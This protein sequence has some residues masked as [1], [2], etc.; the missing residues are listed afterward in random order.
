M[1]LPLLGMPPHVIKG[2]ID[3]VRN[4][5]LGRNVDFYRPIRSA[6]SLCA[7]SG[8]YNPN[9]DG[10][11]F[12]NC[13]VCSGTY[14]ISALEQNTIIA[15]VHWVNDEA[16]EVTPGGKFFTGEATATI[17]PAYLDL[18]ES[19]QNNEG[20]VV[21]DG[22]DMEIVRIIPMGAP[23]INRYRVVLRNMGDRPA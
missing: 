7:A 12:S 18:A 9:S 5:V 17:D 2:H 19:V 10:T 14:W 16:M 8:Y 1:T 11:Y 15:R 23:E 4:N 13:P 22:H 21:V 3:D 20:K 6:C